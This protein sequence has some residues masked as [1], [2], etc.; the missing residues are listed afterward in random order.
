[1]DSFMVRL[2]WQR[3]ADGFRPMSHSRLG[4]VLERIPT[5]DLYAFYRKCDGAKNFSRYFWWALKPKPDQEA[6]DAVYS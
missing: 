2:N 4:K 3:V 6:T 5:G 1:M